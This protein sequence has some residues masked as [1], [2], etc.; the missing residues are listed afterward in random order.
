M[1]TDSQLTGDIRRK[2]IRGERLYHVIIAPFETP[3]VW[4]NVPAATK[5]MAVDFAKEYAVRI[6]GL[7]N[8]KFIVHAERVGK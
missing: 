3:T 4:I 6:L 7:S 1:I 2:A 5:V 8:R